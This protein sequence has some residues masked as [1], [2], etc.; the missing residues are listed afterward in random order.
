[1]YKKVYLL[2][3]L[4]TW[5]VFALQ[6]KAQTGTEGEP[7]LTTE[8]NSATAT[9][10]L[11]VSEVSL[12]KTSAAV[13]NLQLKQQNAGMSVEASA[14]DSTARLLISSVIST[15]QNRTLSARI[16]MGTVPAGTHIELSA[17]QPNANFAGEPGK[18]MSPTTLDGTD[19]PII[20]DIATCYS[21]T[22]ATDGYMLR[23][24]YALDNDR[25]SYGSLRATLGTQVMVTFTLTAAQ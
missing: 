6:V 4:L 8:S 24:N 9:V 20:T 3:L 11:G 5:T 14:S 22:S 2:V 7:V 12:I 23:F 1:M 16:S 17:L 10:V 19:R 15:S 21:G 25:A 18:L 13:I